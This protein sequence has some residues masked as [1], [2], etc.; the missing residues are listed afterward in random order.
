MI[1]PKI[2]S[3]PL[4]KQNFNSYHI[5]DS[6][7]EQINAIMDIIPDLYRKRHLILKSLI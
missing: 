5:I 6:N 3:I 7:L 2:M 4:K 1:S